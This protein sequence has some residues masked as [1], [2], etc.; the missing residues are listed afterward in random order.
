MRDTPRSASMAVTAATPPPI[1]HL[2][3]TDAAAYLICFHKMHY[4]GARRA[5][6]NGHDVLFQIED[7][8]NVAEQRVRDFRLGN[9]DPVDPRALLQTHNFLRNE[10]QRVRAE[11]A[12]VQPVRL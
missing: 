7:P 6:G 5:G 8:D 10:I 2:K 12:D 4:V 9:P 1:Y 3:N 11:V